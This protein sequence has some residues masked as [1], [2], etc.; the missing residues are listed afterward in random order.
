[1][2]SIP[3]MTDGQIL[4]VDEKGRIR[5]PRE[6][7]EALLAE[8]DRSGMTGSGFA[9]WAGIKYPTFAAWLTKRRRAVPKPSG[10][11]VGSSVDSTE[12]ASSKPLRWVEAVINQAPQSTVT[13]AGVSL[14]VHLPCGARMEVSDSHTATLAAEVLRQLT[15]SQPC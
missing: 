10:L 1:M 3:G 9:Q 11:P 15:R 2:Q 7:R 12:E 4:K 14:V 8:F 6:R 13:S 5:I